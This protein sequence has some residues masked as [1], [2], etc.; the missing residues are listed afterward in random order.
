ME[1][2][3][4]R[5]GGD[6]LTIKLGEL[7]ARRAVDVDEAVHVSDAEALDGGLRVLLPLGAEAASLLAGI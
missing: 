5:H 7:V 1:N 4:G 3:H 2:S 6:A